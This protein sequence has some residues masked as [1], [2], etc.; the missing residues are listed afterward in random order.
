[1]KTIRKLAPRMVAILVIALILAAGWYYLVRPY[2]SLTTAW[3]ALVNPTAIVPEGIL[4][5]SGTVE[6]TTLS[7]APELPG[8]VLEVD[9]KEGDVVKAGSVLV[10]LNDSTL[11]I[12][13]SIAAANLETAKLSLQKLAAP[14][15]LANLQGT[16]AQDKQ[17]IDDARQ[18]LDIQKY[19][20][21]NKEAVQNAQAKLFL[22]QDALDKAQTQYDK[23]KYN[24]FFDEN[25]KAAAYQNL[26][27]YKLAYDS[28]LA[29]YNLWTGVPNQEQVDLKTAA[30][31]LANARLVEDQTYLAALNGAPI[32]ANATGAGIV[33]LQQARIN[34]Q[35]AQ[36][37]LNLLNDQ[38]AKMTI[39]APVDGVV[40][41]RSV[42]PGEV[43]NPS[44]ELL[45]LARLNDLTI[46]VYIPA[47]SYGKIKLGQTATVSVDSFPGETFQA[48]VVNISAQPEF[49]PRTTQIVSAS[50]ST[51]YGIQLQL[52]D[53]AGKIKSGMPADV[54]FT[55]K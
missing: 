12:Q 53:A 28:A 35:A 50:K 10:H 4:N 21:N 31:A 55:L 39:T 44:T 11:K 15:V 52:N 51:V 26:Y 18:A 47:D 14:M 54:T 33:Q 9:F 2:G 49:L 37:T 45:S 41:T 43:V 16:I 38:I 5:A 8:K 36:N 17:A 3:D 32:P 42:D 48:T 22:A 25:A 20:T 1:M 19:F 6:T 46:T 13:Q 23:I 29:T 27:R 7:I 24:N 30:L 40:M 34:I